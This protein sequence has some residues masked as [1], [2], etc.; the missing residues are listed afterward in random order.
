MGLDMYL[1]KRTYVKNWDYQKDEQ[2]HEVIVKRG[3]VVRPDIKP[4]RVSYVTE[5][6]AYWRK[7][8]AIHRWFVE[9]V[10]DG[11]DDCGEYYVSRKHL[12]ALVDACQTALNLAVLQEGRVHVGRTFKKGEDGQVVVEENFEDG[13]VVENEGDVASVLPTQPGFF[14]GSTNYDEYYV[15]DLRETIAQLA[16]LLEDEEGGELYYRSSW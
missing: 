14:F 11:E 1:Y 3:G 2:R 6:V 7:A 4:E 12:R 8:N 13:Q 10:Q 5:E 16:P 15:A 9:N